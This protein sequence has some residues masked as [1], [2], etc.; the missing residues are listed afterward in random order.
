[1][2]RQF[3]L[4]SKDIQPPLSLLLCIPSFNSSSG[5]CAWWNQRDMIYKAVTGSSCSA[6]ERQSAVKHA[7]LINTREG[8]LQFRLYLM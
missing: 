2:L 1:M 6:V 3:S 8:D 4:P 5:I 7:P